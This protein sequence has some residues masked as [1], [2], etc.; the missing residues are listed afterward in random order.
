MPL[1][2]ISSAQN[3]QLNDNNL[4]DA[5]FVKV[6]GTDSIKLS[7]LLPN[8]KIEKTLVY[9]PKAGTW[10]RVNFTHAEVSYQTEDSTV[11]LRT[12]SSEPGVGYIL[13]VDDYE[14]RFSLHLVSLFYFFNY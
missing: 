14:K 8:G 4:P 5:Y 3:I 7:Q 11:V 9:L 10:G 2:K 13:S 6:N 12:Q 1:I